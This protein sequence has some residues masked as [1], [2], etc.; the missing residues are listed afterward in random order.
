[1]KMALGNKLGVCV[2][3]NQYKPINKES[4]ENRMLAVM[5]QPVFS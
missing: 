3:L 5:F 1:M 2:F 4:K